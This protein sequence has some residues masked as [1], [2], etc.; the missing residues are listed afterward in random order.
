MTKRTD[1]LPVEFV[2]RMA[3]ARRA[4]HATFEMDT[5]FGPCRHRIT[6]ESMNEHDVRIGHEL[7]QMKIGTVHA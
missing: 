2:E 1:I 6:G 5:P 7:E 4:Y 3:E